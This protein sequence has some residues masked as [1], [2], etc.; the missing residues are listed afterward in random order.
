[1]EDS[2]SVRNEVELGNFF[3]W[4]LA[5]VMPLFVLGFITTLFPGDEIEHSSNSVLSSLSNMQSTIG[6]VYPFIVLAA[7][8]TFGYIHFFRS[9][10]DEKEQNKRIER[11]QGL[12]K[13]IKQRNSERRKLYERARYCED[14]NQFFDPETNISKFADQQGMSSLFTEVVKAKISTEGQS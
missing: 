14:C 12:N 3:G 11:I 8:V 13:L 5:L 4:L 6:Q 2:F 7:I 1:M 9:R 10:P